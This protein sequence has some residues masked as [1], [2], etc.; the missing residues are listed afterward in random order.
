MPGISAPGVT[1]VSHSIEAGSTSANDVNIGLQA[2]ADALST[3][4]VEARKTHPTLEGHIRG[5][6]HIE[7]DGTVRMFAEGN[8]EFSPEEGSSISNDFVGA[9]FGKKY[10]FPQLGDNVLVKIDFRLT[11]E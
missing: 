10:R 4:Y 8:S 11:P 3:L 5:T 7:P 9:T 2:A 1:L 6:F